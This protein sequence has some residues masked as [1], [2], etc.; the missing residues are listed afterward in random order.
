MIA[1]AEKYKEVELTAYTGNLEDGVQLALQH[2][3]QGFDLI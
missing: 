2:M 3:D 1:A